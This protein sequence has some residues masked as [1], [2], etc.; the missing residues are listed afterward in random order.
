M[1]VGSASGAGGQAT[2]LVAGGGIGGL[3]C[4]RALADHGWRVVVCEQAA[5]IG[6]IGAGLQL[7]PNS[8]RVLSKLGLAD[9]IA[10]VA[11]EP[12]GLEM[13]HGK[14]G[15]RIYFVPLRK[16][17]EK[18]WGAPYFHIAR[19]DL[20]DVLATPHPGVRVRTGAKVVSYRQDS[21]SVTV[22]LADGEELTGAVLIG[23][24]GIH[25]A[26]RTQVAG[27]VDPR[28]T[29]LV[30]WRAL[31]PI[32]RLGKHAPPPT[33]CVW[34]GDG[35]HAVTY[36]V[37]RGTL[38]NLVVGGE[39]PGA[40]RQESWTQRGSREQALAEFAGWHPTIAAILDQADTHYRWALFDR[41]PLDTWTDRRVA[42]LGD[43]CHPI[44]PTQGQGAAM[45]I[46]DGWVL[47]DCLAHGADVVEALQHYAQLR[48]P[49]TTAIQT[50]SAQN[51]E[52]FHNGNTVHYAKMRL[53]AR[54][55][56][57]QFTARFDWIYGHDVTTT[58]N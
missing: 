5:D 38:A 11:F 16:M 43:A 39:H 44:L 17:A 6:E 14:S 4:A 24:D 57:D 32:E 51:R 3:A 33:A 46:E 36:R 42:L 48:Q 50:A 35:A 55:H 54:T 8:V 56:P 2:A 12:T 22:S 13:R 21:D 45:A 9:R 18:R 26:I 25:S 37:R 58:T 41:A 31:V 19:T 29:G 30:A 10:G 27:Q 7:S 34:V 1:A 23:A 40:W 15:R 20:I 52:S 53:K 47:A 49:R 28:F